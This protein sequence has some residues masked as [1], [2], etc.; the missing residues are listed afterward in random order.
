MNQQVI[1]RG[2]Q[3][4]KLGLDIMMLP[5]GLSSSFLIAGRVPR[6]KLRTLKKIVG[7]KIQVNEI[8][9]MPSF[10]EGISDP[11]SR[12]HLNPF[13]KGCSLYLSSDDWVYVPAV[14]FKR[15]ADMIKNPKTILKSGFVAEL[16]KK[17]GEIKTI[18]TSIRDAKQQ[19]QGIDAALRNNP[20]TIAGF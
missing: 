11:P 17:I 1:A 9:D 7:N 16:K 8:T 18:F 10:Q 15:N 13:S 20:A 14:G 4:E 19:P 3:V 5:D 6:D 12:C 2:K